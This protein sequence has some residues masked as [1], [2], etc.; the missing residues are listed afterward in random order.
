MIK[1]IKER[2]PIT[3]TEF[4]IDFMYKNDS[5]AGYC[6]PAKSDGTPAL[7]KMC[8]EA[9]AN[10]ER[11]LTDNTLTA[12]EL[13]KEVYNYMEPAVGECTCGKEVVLDGDYMGAVQCEC[14]RWYNLF[15]QS[16]KDPKYWE[17]D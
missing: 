11:C 8:P 6:F 5:N 12:A 2:T 1:I 3:Q 14:G 4:Y 13:R 17:E 7:D 15:G 10:Y 16:L 9:I